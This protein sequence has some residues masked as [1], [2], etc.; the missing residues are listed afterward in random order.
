MSNKP[1][2]A[3]LKETLS[4]LQPADRPLRSCEK[5]GRLQLASERRL[6]PA[7]RNQRP[8]RLRSVGFSLRLPFSKASPG[9]GTFSPDAAKTPCAEAMQLAGHDAHH[10]S[11]GSSSGKKVGIVL[12]LRPAL[13]TF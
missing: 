4:Q 1:W 12:D 11:K 3:Y 7:L 5:M 6:K 10:R 2:L 9:R 13:G 8:V